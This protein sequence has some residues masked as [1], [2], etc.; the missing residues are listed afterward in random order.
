M[1]RLA[2]R[3]LGRIHRAGAPKGKTLVRLFASFICA[4][5]AMRA[6]AG[7]FSK[8]GSTEAPPRVDSRVHM[9]DQ[10]SVVVVSGESSISDLK[11]RLE[12]AVVSP[13]TGDPLRVFTIDRLID[14]CVKKKIFMKDVSVGCKVNGKLDRAGPLSL[15]SSGNTLIAEVPL[16][17]EVQVSGRGEIGKNIKDTI[18]GDPVVVISAS[19]DVSP[20]WRPIV[21]ISVSHSWNKK[22]YLYVLGA[23]ITVEDLANEQIDKLIPK[24]Q[25]L[26]DSWI[27]TLNLRSTAEKYWREGFTTINVLKNPDVWVQISPVAVGLSPVAIDGSKVQIRLMLKAKTKISVGSGLTAEPAS[28]LPSLQKALPP[29]HVSLSVPIYAEL[30]TVEHALG[31]ILKLNETQR[32]NVPLL[33]DVPVIFTGVSVYPT[34][35]NSLAIGLTL[36]AKKPGDLLHTVGTVWLTGRLRLDDNSKRLEPA[37]DAPFDFKGS[38]DNPAVNLLLSIARLPIVTKKVRESLLYVDL[39]QQYQQAVA[40]ISAALNRP[41]APGVNLVATDIAASIPGDVQPAAD[42]IYVGL[43]VSANVAVHVAAQRPN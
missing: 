33:G 19:A 37:S 26:V 9:A 34:S 27:A 23:R 20:D 32:F 24:L 16:H 42:G 7:L 15:R 6:E 28:P 31:E 12:S 10:E 35:N 13:V 5:A 2:C 30:H 14:G 38:T 29:A 36:D 25:E 40:Q 39:S 3:A 11:T 43:N 17:A 1:L 4:L 41:I 18:K 21:K 8:D 22:P